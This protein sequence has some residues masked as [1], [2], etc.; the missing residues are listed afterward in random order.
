MSA[1]KTKPAPA[2]S[3]NLKRHYRASPE[4]VF[5]AWI[6]P[7]QLARWMAPSDDF[8][9]TAVEIDPRPGGRYRFVMTAPDGRDRPS[10]ASLRRSL[11]RAGSCSPGAGKAR[12]SV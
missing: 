7:E 4:R 9:P 6:E 11:P 1:A 2:I 10:V 5:R 3:L 12:P 8:A